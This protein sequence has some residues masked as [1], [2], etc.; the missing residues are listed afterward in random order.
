MYVKLYNINSGGND[1]KQ[2]N[3]TLG[4]MLRTVR[5]S[6]RL[7]QNAVAAQLGVSRS[8]YTYYE[9][10]KTMPDIHTLRQ[11]SELYHIPPEN[12]VYPE[13]FADPESLKHRVPKS[14]LE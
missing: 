13:R 5:L 6:L 4:N 3:L 9:S 7:T 14:V 11:L 10:G 8:T 2:F 1:M 12:F